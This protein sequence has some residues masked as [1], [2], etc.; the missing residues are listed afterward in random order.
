[1][2]VPVADVP[3]FRAP[4]LGTR[5]AVATD[6]VVEAIR[7]HQLIGIDT[8][9]LSE[10][11][12]D[13]GEPH[14]HRAGDFGAHRAGAGRTIWFRRG[15]QHSRQLRPR[16]AHAQC[17]AGRDRRAAGAHARLRY[18]HRALRRDARPAVERGAAPAV[19][20]LL[21]HRHRDDRRGHRRASASNAARCSRPPISPSSGD[22]R[23]KARQ[24]PTIDAAVGMAARHPLR[25][26]QPCTRPI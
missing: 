11:V 24:S 15:A 7:P 2:P 26:G 16:R 23:R 10:V 3:I 21:R 12:V 1:M 20:A 18:A 25:P 13:P 5:G 8:R 9:G 19:D 14:H 4:D 6:R 22:R 17:R